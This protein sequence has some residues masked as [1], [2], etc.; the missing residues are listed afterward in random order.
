MD[1]ANRTQPEKRL[2]WYCQSPDLHAAVEEQRR[3]QAPPRPARREHGNASTRSDG[4]TYVIGAT[5]RAVVKI[6]RT[7]GNPR[8]RM[9]AMQT[10]SPVPLVLLATLPHPRWEDVLHAH[11]AE[12]RQQGEWF[13]LELGDVA[14]IMRWA[15]QAAGIAAEW[16]S[17]VDAL[18]AG[19]DETS[20][21]LEGVYGTRAVRAWLR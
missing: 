17:D 21:A 16:P 18:S 5:E 12:Q 19:W 15:C 9:S 20:A 14:A 1:S 6:G 7:T 10:G 11:Y 8:A 2:P 4:I 3:H 13:A